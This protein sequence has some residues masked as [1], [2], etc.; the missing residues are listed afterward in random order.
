MR[1]FIILFLT[2]IFGGSASWLFFVKPKRKKAIAEAKG[3][4]LDNIEKAISI[5]R[6]LF[7]ESEKRLLSKQDQF[8]RTQKEH[9]KKIKNFEEKICFQTDCKNR[10]K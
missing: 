7:E 10:I 4:E 8:E 2:S 9:S 5:W 3:T 6:K 1:E